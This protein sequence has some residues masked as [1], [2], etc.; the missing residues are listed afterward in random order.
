[1]NFNAEP[2]LGHLIFWLGTFFML[3]ADS[4]GMEIENGLPM[5]RI[6]CQ[7]RCGEVVQISEKSKNT[8][9][10]QIEFETY[11]TTGCSCDALCKVYNDCCFDFWDNCAKEV[12]KLR[13]DLEIVVQT[14]SNHGNISSWE[15]ICSEDINPHK[16]KMY[17]FVSVCLSTGE[18]CLTREN[19]D[20]DLFI[21]VHDTITGLHYVHRK[22][23]LCNNARNIMPWQYHVSCI[24]NIRFGQDRNLNAKQL[25]Q[26]Y[27]CN[28]I[29]DGTEGN[30]GLRSYPAKLNVVQSCKED[31]E[32]YQEFVTKC[33]DGANNFM[34]GM[35]LEEIPRTITSNIYDI[36]DYDSAS[37]ET[38]SEHNWVVSNFKNI[39]CALCN[40]VNETYISQ[41]T[42][43]CQLSS[44]RDILHETEDYY[45]YD[46]EYDYD[47]ELYG[48]EAIY[49]DEITPSQVSLTV[50]FEFHGQNGFTVKDNL[51]N[52]T[53]SIRTGDSCISLPT[54]GDIVIQYVLKH[55]GTELDLEK[56]VSEATDITKIIANDVGET[57]IEKDLEGFC[58]W[59]WQS[60]LTG[61]DENDNFS[62]TFHCHVTLNEKLK[63]SD[64]ATI[65]TDTERKL[66]T[67][68]M[69]INM[70]FNVIN[71]SVEF[72]DTNL[73]LPL[74]Y[75]G[76]P[77]FCESKW[78]NKNSTDR[79][80]TEVLITKDEIMDGKAVT[81]YY[82]TGHVSAK[83]NTSIIL[84]LIT[85]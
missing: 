79:N 41:D 5:D 64:F 63:T 23:A 20:P 9:F 12:Q 16:C 62:F 65:L 70:T 38:E 14:V 3:Y 83:R 71:I 21:P 34:S 84:D 51:C 50:L 54:E 52:E 24:S 19:L 31:S 68:I 26:K 33:T 27:G 69:K 11:A 58:S 49:G 78:R 6:S 66:R 35:V 53:A 48:K 1:M 36:Y 74:E 39:F 55:F 44:Y 77:T 10:L 32:Y 30:R 29:V 4:K 46:Y 42:L 8:T 15:E 81:C 72:G 28:I 85:A 82:K 7:D 22:C 18:P 2:N 13:D 25:L 59:T 45:G 56:L 60:S 37:G 17:Q 67:N 47:Y 57:S 75:S 80:M 43:Y 76:L 61:N 40:K 73:I